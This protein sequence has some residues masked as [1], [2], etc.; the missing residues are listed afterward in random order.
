M[1]KRKEILITKLYAVA[2]HDVASSPEKWLFLLKS[3]SRNY[4]LPL[5]E[6]L[7]VHVQSPNATAVLELE[8]WNKV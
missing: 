2:V 3:A 5:D 8:K 1:A 6:Q 7:L 4:R